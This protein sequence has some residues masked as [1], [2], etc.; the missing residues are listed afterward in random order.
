M[1]TKPTTLY[2][3]DAEASVLEKLCERRGLS[4]NALLR[5]ALRI[6]Q[7][8]DA[9]AQNGEKLFFEDKGKEKSE[10]ILV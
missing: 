1:K 9:K 4:K 6:Y 8:V 7:L 2:L 10:L 5:Q 3:N